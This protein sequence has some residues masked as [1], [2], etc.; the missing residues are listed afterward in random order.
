M[1]FAISRNLPVVL[2]GDLNS[3][4][5]SAVY[6]FLASQQVDISHPDVADAHGILPD[7]RG[8]THT[9][10]LDSAY[11]AI[12]GSEP[13]YTNYTDAF[14]GVLDYI[15]FDTDNVRPV[16]VSQML[17]VSDIEKDGTALPNAQWGSDHVMMISDLQII[18]N[19]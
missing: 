4:P 13:A 8:I 18:G 5:S 16:S 1:Q 9:L 3:T 11:R 17:A 6:S 7:A 14:K 12:S 2:C 10:P 15:W 19:R